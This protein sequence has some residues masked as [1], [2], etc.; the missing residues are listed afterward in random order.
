VQ[1]NVVMATNMY[2]L[3]D[4]SGLRWFAPFTAAL[5]VILAGIA[6]ALVYPHLTG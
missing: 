3:H 1:D 4:R 2:D 6:L 5:L